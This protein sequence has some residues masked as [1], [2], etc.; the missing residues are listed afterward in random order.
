M[1][2]LVRCQ[3][4]MLGYQTCGSLGPLCCIA[5][6][7]MKKQDRI[8]SPAELGAD[9]ADVAAAGSCRVNRIPHPQRTRWFKVKALKARRSLSNLTLGE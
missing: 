6:Q 8:S 9:E 4:A 2:P 7:A 5:S 3:N 1:T